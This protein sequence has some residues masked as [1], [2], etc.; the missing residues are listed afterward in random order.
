MWTC[1]LPST[2]WWGSLSSWLLAVPP[3]ANGSHCF[4]HTFRRSSNGL[5]SAGSD[6]ITKFRNRVSPCFHQWFFH[7]RDLRH[8][9]INQKPHHVTWH[10]SIRNLSNGIRFIC[11]L[12]LASKFLPSLPHTWVILN[13]GILKWNW[14]SSSLMNTTFRNILSFQATNN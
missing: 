9:S 5:L 11:N 4:V 14:C 7:L 1:L 8:K 3:T 2:R 6:F 12:L 10:Y 13:K